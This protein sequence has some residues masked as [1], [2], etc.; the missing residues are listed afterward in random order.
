LSSPNATES[1]Q[2]FRDGSNCA[3]A[4]LATYFRVLGYDENLAHRLGAGLG[5]GIGRKQY[6][7]GA[8]NAGAMVISLV[9]GN[10]DCLDK[11]HKE[12][13]SLLVKEFMEAFEKEFHTSQCR[14]L[15]GMDT[16]TPEGRQKAA[17]A[18]LYETVCVACITRV[19]E[20]VDKRVH[21]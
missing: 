2:R 18:G 5:G 9:F 11:E 1:L 20:L 6:V 7:C 8:V 4:V 13:T 17:D 12:A 16:S 3:Q 14:D 15:L 10:E 21:T 19:C